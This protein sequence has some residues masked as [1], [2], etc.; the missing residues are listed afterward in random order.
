KSNADL[1]F[2]CLETE[3]ALSSACDESLVTQP[4]L[5][6]DISEHG[7]LKNVIKCKS[8][9]PWA[10]M[11]MLTFTPYQCCHDTRR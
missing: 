9:Q 7:R 2:I 4:F 3:G 1:K 6:C 8:S 11:R 10:A 5:S